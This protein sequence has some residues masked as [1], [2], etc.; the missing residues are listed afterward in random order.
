MRLSLNSGYRASKAWHGFLEASRV[1]AV[2]CFADF[3]RREHK[4]LGLHRQ[5]P[6]VSAHGDRERQDSGADAVA[7]VGNSLRCLKSVSTA[8]QRSVCS[9]ESFLA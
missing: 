5:L 9:A 2:H 1:A 3:D 6:S 7:D 8:F 4:E